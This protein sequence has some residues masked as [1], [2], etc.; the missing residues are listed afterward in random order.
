MQNVS[1][2]S[3]LFILLPQ[4]GCVWSS[5]LGCTLAGLYRGPGCMGNEPRAFE[6]LLRG[7]TG[8]RLEDPSLAIG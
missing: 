8:R 2:V 1:F 6:I 4:E 3:F 7:S 5:G